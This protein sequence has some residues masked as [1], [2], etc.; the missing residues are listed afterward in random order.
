MHSACVPSAARAAR[1]ALGVFFMRPGR[2][3]GARRTHP[4]TGQVAA[5]SDWVAEAE[6]TSVFFKMAEVLLYKCAISLC[7]CIC[8]AEA[9]QVHNC[10]GNHVT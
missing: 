3:A 10:A 6:H 4:G 7:G 5:G 1:A 2:V 8:S 9:F